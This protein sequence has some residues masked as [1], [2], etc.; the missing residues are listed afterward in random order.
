[1]TKPCDLSA[2]EARRLIGIKALSPVELL[3]SCL[4]RIAETNGTL[5]AVVAMD[6]AAAKANAKAAEKAVADGE[7]LGLLHGLPVGIKDLNP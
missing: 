3:D 4:E 7:D 6:E 5:N 2:I 1:M